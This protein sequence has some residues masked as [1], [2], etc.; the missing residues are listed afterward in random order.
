ME[1][2][3]YVRMDSCSNQ[4]T[5]LFLGLLEQEFFRDDTLNID[6]KPPM[7]YLG[8]TSLANVTCPSTTAFDA[9]ASD[10]ATILQAKFRGESFQHYLYY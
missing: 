8:Q 5:V 4:Y 3:I 7:H 6:I 10:A 1:H 9:L 2:I